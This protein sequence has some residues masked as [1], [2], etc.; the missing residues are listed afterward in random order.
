M[1]PRAI[2]LVC[3]MRSAK[4][5]V[6]SDKNACARSFPTVLY[7]IGFRD[8]V[9]FCDSF[10]Q[11]TPR[12]V[13]GP[14]EIGTTDPRGISVCERYEK[15]GDFSGARAINGT[16]RTS[17]EESSLSVERFISASYQ[18]HDFL[19]KRGEYGRVLFQRAL[20]EG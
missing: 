10:P 2:E 4:R 8:G 20:D 18:G 19:G 1:A 11:T 9:A 3:E 12:T 13:F 7:R 15:N 16:I 14:K 5:S 17:W 6:S